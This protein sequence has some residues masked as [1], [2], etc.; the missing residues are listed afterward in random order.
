MKSALKQVFRPSWMNV[1]K[2]VSLALGICISAALMCKVAWER[3]FDNFWEE[4]EKLLYLETDYA[5][6]NEEDSVISN[7]SMKSVPGVAPEIVQNIA[8][9]KSAARLFYRTFDYW[10]GE[11]YFP[12]TTYYVD[13]SF[14]NVLQIKMIIGDNL[15]DIL[16]DSEKV[17]ISEK[18][19]KK[20]FPDGDPLG[21][22]I[23]NKHPAF[24]QDVYTIC[25]IYKDLPKNSIF[26]NIEIILIEDLPYEFEGGS[27]WTTLLRTYQKPDLEKLNNEINTLLQPRYKDRDT[28]ISFRVNFLRDCHKNSVKENNAMLYLLAFA[29]LLISGLSFALL[30]I[31]SLTSRA[32]EVG[33]R[34]AAGANASGIFSMILWETV[35]Y[36]LSATL[37]SAII[38][39]GFKP[40]LENIIGSYEEIFAF[41]TLWAIG[42]VLVSLIIIAGALPAQIFSRI[43]VTQVFQRFTSDRIF[44]KRVL[45]FIQFTASIFVICFMCIIL[46]QYHTSFKRDFGYDKEK[47][48]WIWKNISREQKQI[49]MDEISSDSRVEA[50]TVN[51]ERVWLDFSFL[52]VYLTPETEDN[53]LIPWATTD[54]MFFKTYGIPI[55]YGSNNLT[56][57]IETGGNV[58]VNEAFLEKLNIVDNPIGHVFYYRKNRPA[59][60]VG[61]CR[62][63]ESVS[64]GLQ[65]TVMMLHDMRQGCVITVRVKEV[66]KET[67]EAI[68]EKVKSFYP[69]DVPPEVLTY[70][71]NISDMFKDVRMFRDK[72]ILTSFFLLLITIMGILGYVNLE[73]RRRTKEIAIRKIH[74]ST[75][76][77]VI[78]KVS[79]D[80]LFIALLAAAVAVPLAYILRGRWQQEFARKVNLSWYRFAAGVFIVVPT[81][82]V[83]ATLQTWHT[84]SANPAR[85]LSSE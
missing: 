31:N 42:V 21:Q 45:L 54:S 72:I 18:T 27:R 62:N 34:K 65:P 60:I 43:P 32:K 58:V 77:E 78:W 23:L 11:N 13:T 57:N 33:V 68:Q 8:A 41:G 46:R 50:V 44:W 76:I 1:V 49:L 28:P 71:D 19:A 7:Y 22:Q 48:I 82:A 83:C 40:Q 47:L 3:S 74:G 63:F 75:A 79:R 73:I 39:W 52:D 24:G 14:F 66:N 51:S 53:F 6:K 84:A 16:G 5:Y 30:S 26:P 35:F 20:L 12:L 2:I 64:G 17:I 59:T 80:L 37:L 10:V 55:L 9:V 67:I 85:G 4:K 81:I 15:K 38:F 70:S 69:N 25:G 29:L 56:A 61:V 36:V